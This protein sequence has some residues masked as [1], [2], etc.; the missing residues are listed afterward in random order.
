MA[1][2]EFSFALDRSGGEKLGITFI[3]PDGK[4]DAQQILVTDVLA[5]SL[6]ARA[7]A[8]DANVANGVI[9]VGDELVRLNGKHAAQLDL[10]SFQRELG[11]PQVTMT[12]AR[13]DVGGGLRL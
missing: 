6:A 1:D 7:R 8:L 11:M 13:A 3:L 5:G 10:A 9:C 4:E 2:A 12:F